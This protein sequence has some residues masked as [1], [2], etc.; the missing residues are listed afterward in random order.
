MERAAAALRDGSAVA[1]S[2][3]PRSLHL[4]T[5]QDYLLSF[6][7]ERAVKEL[8]LPSAQAQMQCYVANL[9][10]AQE[11]FQRSE[12]KDFG[13]NQEL[14]LRANSFAM[15]SAG[16]FVLVPP[17]ADVALSTRRNLLGKG[18]RSAAVKQALLDCAL[19]FILGPYYVYYEIAK[20]VFKFIKAL[21]SMY[22][23]KLVSQDGFIYGLH[24][25]K[26]EIYKKRSFPNKKRR[27][28]QITANVATVDGK[29]TELTYASPKRKHCDDACF[30]SL[31]QELL[32]EFASDVGFAPPHHMP[33][34]FDFENRQI[35]LKPRCTFATSS[36]PLCS[37]RSGGEVS[38]MQQSVMTVA[39]GNKAVTPFQERTFAHYAGVGTADDPHLEPPTLAVEWAEYTTGMKVSA[40]HCVDYT[41]CAAVLPALYAQMPSSRG[42]AEE[43]AEARHRRR[44]AQAG[45]GFGSRDGRCIVNDVIDD[46]LD[47]ILRCLDGC[48]GVQT[49]SLVSDVS[50]LNRTGMLDVYKLT[51]R[52]LDICKTLPE[53]VKRAVKTADPKGFLEERIKGNFNAVVDG[54]KRRFKAEVRSSAL[55]A[56]GLDESDIGTFKGALAKV[57]KIKQLANIKADTLITLA[58]NAGLEARAEGLSFGDFAKNMVEKAKDEFTSIFDNFGDI[59]KNLKLDFSV[60]DDIDWKGVFDID[61]KAS[62]DMNCEWESMFDKY[63]DTFRNY[64]MRWPAFNARTVSTALSS[65]NVTLAL[66]EMH[67]LVAS[68]VR[69]KLDEVTAGLQARIDAL[70]LKSSEALDKAERVAD[71]LCKL[72]F[73]SMCFVSDVEK[74]QGKLGRLEDKLDISE[75]LWSL[76]PPS[77]RNGRRRRGLR[78][79][80]GKLPP[81]NSVAC[82]M[83]DPTRARSRLNCQA[84]GDDPCACGGLVA[85]A[86]MLSTGVYSYRLVSGELGLDYSDV[87]ED[88]ARFDGSWMLDEVH[89]RSLPVDLLSL[90]FNS[91]AKGEIH[92][93][94]ALGYVAVAFRGTEPE[95]G[96]WVNNL[97]VLPKKYTLGRKC[98]SVHGG[99]HSHLGELLADG[100][101]MAALRTA[102]DRVGGTSRA[103]VLITG[104]SLGGAMAQLFAVH[105]AS[106]FLSDMAPDRVKVVTFGSPRVGN[107]AF[108]A[109]LRKASADITLYRAECSGVSVFGF[110]VPFTD[111]KRFSDAVTH[112]PPL[113]LPFD[114]VKFVHALEPTPILVH[115]AFSVGSQACHMNTGYLDAVVR[116]VDSMCRRRASWAGELGGGAAL[117]AFGTT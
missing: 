32:E 44:L 58:C 78:A 10:E 105:L 47:P 22:K 108:G 67:A 5:T 73:D 89:E 104:H 25:I 29:S 90:D 85:S 13:M 59:L 82:V 36:D 114:G 70:M 101:F 113:S 4:A 33:V 48:A 98:G 77:V 54:V 52:Q 43:G 20:A 23:K 42:N 93:N 72:P 26:M 102:I 12:E 69:S 57:D 112:V 84:G 17:H 3:L 21:L 27:W 31:L 103:R 39:S 61:W 40:S 88:P 8:A 65:A 19:K 35:K 71:A 45:L 41:E 28:V 68:K 74:L 94:E 62:F 2:E 64:K 107:G 49:G 81:L 1:S 34:A 117:R 63:G 75:E 106:S 50:A 37:P 14:T 99:F 11:L 97:H 53:C 9:T 100:T 86:A 76:L 15:T 96:Q 83:H 7:L 6:P 92:V 18:D 91:D 66:D 55:Q 38:H 87:L 80:G 24:P 111:S 115:E 110:E 51:Q 30:A 60:F 56:I 116:E 16:S 46:S 79:D 95:L 109:A